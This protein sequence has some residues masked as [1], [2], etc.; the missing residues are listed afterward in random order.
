MSAYDL[1]H[2]LT[3]ERVQKAK[4]DTFK[5]AEEE[6]RGLLYESQE[7][8]DLSVEIE[9]QHIAYL[10]EGKENKDRWLRQV[11]L[12]TSTVQGHGH[13]EAVEGN[14]LGTEQY[15]LIKMV[16][17]TARVLRDEGCLEMPSEQEV[18][19]GYKKDQWKYLE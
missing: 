8:K 14:G 5:L 19:E 6:V 1:V 13:R 9:K 3:K 15:S 7:V 4:T 18:S 17:Y 2:F 12:H 16:V 11:L 10:A